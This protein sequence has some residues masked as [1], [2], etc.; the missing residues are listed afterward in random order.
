MAKTKTRATLSPAIFGLGET[1][2]FEDI[3][4]VPEAQAYAAGEVTEG[5]SADCQLDSDENPKKTPFLDG[6]V[7]RAFSILVPPHVQNLEIETL[8]TGAGTGSIDVDIAGINTN[9]ASG[10]ASATV[11]TSSTGTGLLDVSVT[12]NLT[13]GSLD[14]LLV[15]VRT[16]PIAAADIPDPEDS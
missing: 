7:V 16:Q 8:T 2:F 12:T 3:Q 9:L 11:A 5:F 15:R 4:V 1:I 6:Q 10:S 13:S 14:L